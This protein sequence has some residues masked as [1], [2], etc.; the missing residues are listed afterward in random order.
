[1]I[2]DPPYLRASV[3]DLAVIDRLLNQ[4][5][6]GPLCLGAPSRAHSPA[7]RAIDL[8]HV[9]TVHLTA[10]ARRRI[11]TLDRANQDVEV[12]MSEPPAMWGAR[13]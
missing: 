12:Q 9:F 2:M 11:C 8:E 4:S 13:R 3:Q 10:E 7:W 1:V 5:L 6:H